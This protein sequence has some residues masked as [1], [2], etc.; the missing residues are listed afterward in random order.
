MELFI[1][2]SI[3]GGVMVGAVMF[4]ITRS[5]NREVQAWEELIR[6]QEQRTQKF[7]P[8]ARTRLTHRERTIEI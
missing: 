2:G 4:L 6:E 3:V 7:R 5:S 1:F 8:F